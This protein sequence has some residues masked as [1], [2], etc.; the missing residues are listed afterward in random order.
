M[1]YG[2]DQGLS[3]WKYNTSSGTYQYTYTLYEVCLASDAVFFIN[4][5][6]DSIENI[7]G[8]EQLGSVTYSSNEVDNTT[9]FTFTTKAGTRP[10][11]D[12]QLDFF[13]VLNETSTLPE[14]VVTI[15][16][17]SSAD[18]YDEG[19]WEITKNSTGNWTW[20]APSEVVSGTLSSFGDDLIAI[21]Y[22]PDLNMTDNEQ[23]LEPNAI[24]V[25]DYLSSVDCEQDDTNVKVTLTFDSKILEKYRKIPRGFRLVII[26]MNKMANC[27]QIDINNN[28]VGPIS[29]AYANLSYKTDEDVYY[30]RV[31]G[32]IPW[33]SVR[34]GSR[35][36]VEFA[37]ANGL[38]P[39]KPQIIYT[40]YDTDQFPYILEARVNGGSEIY[41]Y[42]L[43]SDVKANRL[44]GIDAILIDPI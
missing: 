21:I 25:Y 40:P 17:P 36:S 2:I 11:Y 23:D 27:Y 16:V 39:S 24:A 13:A 3:N 43:A 18:V 28:W 37:N 4:C 1:L 31:T 5:A 20:E 19:T 44:S 29:S 7:N 35:T 34:D 15:S 41:F 6:D 9:T 38:N 10:D 22:R 42:A 26:G 8:F 33:E 32:G 14:E 12:V 30:N